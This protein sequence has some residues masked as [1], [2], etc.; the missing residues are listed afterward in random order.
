VKTNRGIAHLFLLIIVIIVAIG[1]IGYLAYQNYQSKQEVAVSYPYPKQET[2]EVAKGEPVV[3]DQSP[4]ILNP[5]DTS[6]WKVENFSLSRYDSY[7]G[8]LFEFTLSFT[9]PQ[10]WSVK[11]KN[12]ESIEREIDWPEEI[13][14]I[15]YETA[16]YVISNPGNTLIMNF[17]AVLEGVSEWYLLPLNANLVGTF[18]PVPSGGAALAWIIR[19]EDAASGK[20]RYALALTDNEGD[21]LTTNNKVSPWTSLITN[22]LASHSSGK[23]YVIEMIYTGSDKD[24]GTNITTADQIISLLADWDWNIKIE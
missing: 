4:I 13:G 20:I 18:V 6:D 17:D 5:L 7:R 3:L 14:R 23:M 10:N 22:P 1:A 2:K 24:Y 21:Q 16:D 15:R 12:R 11:E 8:E 9:I 19:Y